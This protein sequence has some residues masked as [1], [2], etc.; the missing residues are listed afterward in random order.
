MS[1]FAIH[2]P[3]VLPEPG[4]GDARWQTVVTMSGADHAE[5]ELHERIEDTG[6]AEWRMIASANASA[7][8]L[9]ATVERG[10]F[11]AAT[12]PIATCGF[13][14][15]FAELGVEFGPSFRALTEIRRGDG[16]AEGIVEIDAAGTPAEGA[17]VLHPRL[18]D[19]AMQLCSAALGPGENGRTPHAIFLPIGAEGFHLNRTAASSVRARARLRAPGTAESLVADIVIESLDGTP[20]AV[21]DGMRFVRA[22]RSAFFEQGVLDDSLYEVRWNEAEAHAPVAGTQS[23]AGSWLIFADKSG[24]A[25]AIAKELAEHGGKCVLVRPG[26][27]LREVEPAS[28][29]IDPAAA[30]QFGAL[31][32][33]VDA[34]STTRGILHLWALD[35]AALDAPDVRDAAAEDLLGTGV[36]LHITQALARRPAETSVPLWVVTAG[37]EAAG[38]GAA[39]TTPRAAGLRGMASAIAVEHPELWCRIV[40]LDASDAAVHGLF[41]ELLHPGDANRVALRDGKRRVPHLARYSARSGESAG[42]RG[43]MD[44]AL[45]VATAGTFEG[46]EVAPRARGQLGRDEVR[47]R[48]VAAGVNFRDVLLTLGMYPGTGIELGAECAGIVIECGAGVTEFAPGDRVFGFAPGSMASEVAVP[49]GFLIPTPPGVSAESAAALPVAMMTAWYGLFRL[50]GLERGER[51]LIHAGTGG[52]GMAAVQLAVRCGA[53]VFATAGTP[54]K[55]ALLLSRGVTHVFDSR[56]IEFSRGVLERTAGAG[57]DVV[58]NS[59]SG[60]FIRAGVDALA[61]NGRF[62]EIGKR[63]VWS[64]EQMAALRPDVRYLPYDLGAEALADPSLLRPML[65]EMSAALR[66]GTLTPLPVRVFPFEHAQEAFRFMA[67]AKHV[68]KLVLKLPGSN[69]SELES[70]AL[71]VPNATY[72]I[73]GGAGALGLQTARWLADSGATHLVLTGRHELDGARADALHKLGSGNVTVR[74]LRAD[75]ADAGRMRDVLHEIRTSMPPLRGIVHAAGVI[76]D[77][78]VIQQDWAR[79]LGVLRGKAHGAFVMHA[80]TLDVPLDF[81]VL[82]SAAGLLLGPSGQGSYA[83]ANAELDALAFARRAVG[84]PAL[85][86]AWGAW[87]GVGMAAETARHGHDSWGARGLGLIDAAHGFAALEQLMRAGVANAAVL[88]I[89]W[90]RFLKTAPEGLRPSFFEMVAPRDASATRDA[91]TNGAGEFI[92]RLRAVPASSRTSVLAEYLRERALHVIGLPMGTNI[93]GRTPLKELGLDSLMA[94]ELRNMLVRLTGRS[95]PATLLFDYPTL[96][97]LAKYLARILELDATPARSQPTPAATGIAA[98]TDDEAEA[99]LLAELER[100]APGARP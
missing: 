71:V 12:E 54:V 62:L 70:T 83:A 44:V 29:V 7:H 93:D 24:V 48:V 10:A 96:D 88:P 59:L 75:A 2:R 39:V 46:L 49:A 3:C 47:L 55:R 28:W 97:T 18:L 16:F 26:S 25:E 9:N 82:Y 67:Q 43:L 63:G 78:V 73:T 20:I 52:V 8:P 68:G 32:A 11:P 90:A 40:D 13:Y 21:I 35:L 66:D 33:A 100:G 72:L 14:D 15:R 80:L 76:D 61:T 4:Q 91:R 50:A 17:F 23:A 34:G 85:S 31:F 69:E 99:E 79:C 92:A 94:V 86:V 89:D 30:P 38:D 53:E 6:G 65:E 27:E 37:A 36:L 1:D 42:H 84:L 45:R 57:V 56:S 60:D 5:I 74:F 64:A 81:F 41:A 87:G 98:L 51:I 19:A 58:L 77:G 95:L 22:E